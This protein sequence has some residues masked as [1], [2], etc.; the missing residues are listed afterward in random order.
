VGSKEIKTDAR[1]TVTTIGHHTIVHTVNCKRTDSGL[2]HLL[3][4]N[5]SGIDEGS[6][7]VTVLGKKII[8]NVFFLKLSIL[9]CN[10]VSLSYNF[11]MTL[12][13]YL[14]RPGPPGEPLVY[15]DITSSSVTLSW[16]LPKDNG[17]SEIT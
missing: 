1:T 2:Y 12:L 15:E 11:K 7:T 5:S 10:D 9:F 16:T 4:R 13:F 3:L 8:L 6:F 14:D 17:G